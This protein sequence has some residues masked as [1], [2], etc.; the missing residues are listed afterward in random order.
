MPSDGLPKVAKPTGE[1]GRYRALEKEVADGLRLAGA[2][3]ERAAGLYR[4]GPANVDSVSPTHQAA[5]QDAPPKDYVLPVKIGSIGQLPDA[6]PLRLLRVAATRPK[7]INSVT[8]SRL[9]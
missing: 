8:G 9:L 4:G 2:T 7:H 6:P 3:R 5:M 1:C